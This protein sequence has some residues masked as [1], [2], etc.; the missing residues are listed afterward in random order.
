MGHLVEF[1]K[2]DMGKKLFSAYLRACSEEFILNSDIKVFLPPHP[3]DA[4]DCGSWICEILALYQIL[5]LERL[6]LLQHLPKKEKKKKKTSNFRKIINPTEGRCRKYNQ[7]YYIL[8]NLT[9][10]FLTVWLK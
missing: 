7:H 10:I 6:H 2:V 1:L 3:L 8:L 9:I 5:Y 4:F